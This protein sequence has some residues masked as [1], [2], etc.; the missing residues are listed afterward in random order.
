MTEHR[1][2]KKLE[3]AELATLARAG[4]SGLWAILQ[5]LIA[6]EQAFLQKEREENLG[7]CDEDFRRDVRWFMSASECLE[8]LTRL[9]RLAQEQIQK[10]QRP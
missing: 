9:P 5:K 7:I 10:E 4:G 2:L 6:E 1:A 8:W 3:D